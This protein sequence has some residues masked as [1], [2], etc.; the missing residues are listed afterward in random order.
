LFAHIEHTRSRVA[1]P[2]G[3]LRVLRDLP[4]R[5]YTSLADVEEEVRKIRLAT[6][7]AIARTRRA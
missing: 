2:E 6:S 3:V 7:A 5:R 1:H 4:Q